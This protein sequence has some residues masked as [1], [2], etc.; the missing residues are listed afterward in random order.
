MCDS[1]TA[2]SRVDRRSWYMLG[3]LVLVYIMGSVDRA[4]PSVVVEPLKRDST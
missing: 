2:E 3:I 4:V 1:S